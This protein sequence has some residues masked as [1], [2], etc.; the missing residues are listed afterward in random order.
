M[1][2]TTTLEK[3]KDYW[4]KILDIRVLAFSVIAFIGIHGEMIFNKISWGDDMSLLT[5]GNFGF[6]ANGRWLAMAI[7]NFVKNYAGAESTPTFHSIIA[8]LSLA[9]IAC[10]YIHLF[11]I[12]NLISKFAVALIFV[13]IP[14]IASHLGYM[15]YMGLDYFGLII[16]A[17]AVLIIGDNHEFKVW[18]FIAAA[19]VLCLS[20]GMYQWHLTVYLTSILLLLIF[21]LIVDKEMTAVKFL[22]RGLYLVGSAVIGTGLYLGVLQWYLH[23]Y[24]VSLNWYA[25]IDTYGVVSIEEYVS[26]LK[27]AYTDFW[28]PAIDTK[29]AIFPFHNEAWHI[30]LMR[31]L[32]IGAI[33]IAVRLILEKRYIAVGEFAFCIALIP[34][35][36]N[37]NFIL[38]GQI[39]THAIHM[40]HFGLLFM[41]LIWMYQTA[42]PFYVEQFEHK[43]V[44][45]VAAFVM[46]LA[47]GF[48][49][50]FG[51]VWARYDNVCYLTAE[52]HMN[53]SISYLNRMIARMESAEGYSKDM[54]VCIVG[55]RDNIIDNDIRS[56]DKVIN[57]YQYNPINCGDTWLYLK[58]Y[59]G[60]Q[61]AVVVQP[62]DIDLYSNEEFLAMPC[63]PNNGSIK[64]IEGVLVV[65]C[66]YE[67]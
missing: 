48:V 38:Y 11:N 19:V 2:V 58:N 8:A 62:E 23:H 37:F 51:V 45:E 63:Y 16:V 39:N 1:E 17:L 44:K 24:N 7:W 32:I 50:V 65:K 21:E 25:G 33:L 35:A 46:A 9:V 6:G 49:L 3:I 4:A 41:I 43:A 53:Q 29:Y 60:Y 64:R 10:I 57:P 66:Y 54:P 14:S 27:L 36:F 61:P 34:M 56:Y 5:E 40:W 15:I 18:R 13:S 31:I 59:C 52:L 42:L 28:N 55:D 12:E 47:V 26:R 67:Q 22:L 30:W 20:L